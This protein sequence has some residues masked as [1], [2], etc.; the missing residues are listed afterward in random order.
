MEDY[1][2]NLIIIG[3]AE[4]KADKCEILKEVVKKTSSKGGPLIVLTAATEY[5]EEVGALYKK[6]FNR[7]HLH[8]IKIIDIKDRHD[9][10]KVEFCKEIESSGCV[11]FTGGDQLKITSLIGGTGLYE[12]LKQAYRNGTLIVGTSA[13]ASCVCSTMVVSGKDD[14]SPRK[15]ALKMAPGLDIIRGVLIDQHFAQRGRIGRLLGGVAQNPESLGI[16]IDENTA[17]VVEGSSVFRVIGS[18]AVTVID[19]SLITH[20]NISELLP[21]ETLAIT[22]IKIH[23]L[24][25]GYKY[26][27]RNRVPIPKRENK[28]DKNEDS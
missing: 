7:L 20:T 8:D 16:G 23:I 15:V 26:D 2:G 1:F 3:G 9:A 21:Q 24:P 11:F 27:M 25:R 13:G 4:D 18:G 10:N 5:P 19:G 17:I 28:E 14:D 12:S 6:T 22:D